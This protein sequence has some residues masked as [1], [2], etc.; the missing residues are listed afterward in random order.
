MR[1]V[2]LV[3]VVVLFGVLQ[4]V[5]AQGDVAN[6][7]P[8][9]VFIETQ[10]GEPSDK[11]NVTIRFVDVIT[12]EE[13]TI[14]VVGER[15]TIAGHSLVYWDNRFQQVRVISPDGSIRNHPF[16][17]PDG[18]A[19]RVDWVVSNDGKLS[20]WALAF[21]EG[22]LLSSVIYMASGNGDNI[23]E[24][25]RDDNRTDGLRLVPVALSVDQNELYFDYM[26]D[27]LQD[28]TLFPQY[29]ALSYVDLESGES[30]F[31]PDEPGDF[32]GAGFG[33]GYFVRL[34]LATTNVGFDISVFDL[35]RQRN[36]QLS[37]VGA[38]EYTQAGN[39]LISPDGR[40]AV[41]S[42]LRI[43]GVENGIQDIETL[44]ILADLTEGTQTII[45]DSLDRLLHPVHWMGDNQYVLLA[46][47][48]DNVTYE[49]NT[50]TL[51]LSETINQAY[52]GTLYLPDA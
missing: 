48:I 18:G 35:H 34:G 10:I 4:S 13:N 17:Q 45:G 30:G 2:V 15:F 27:G 49:L 51:N 46:D 41:Y 42:L 22:D 25:I 14:D 47:Y 40:F 36:W 32:T 16:I 11:D 19:F 52:L 3:L 20:A 7:H 37:S 31:L 5:M 23:R 44:L 6:N 43:L 26:L 39:V 29:A 50:E 8:Y 33:S 12:G 21:R 1:R 38:P 24:V 28:L 9:Y